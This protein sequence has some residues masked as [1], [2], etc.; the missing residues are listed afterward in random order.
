MVRFCLNALVALALFI[1]QNVTLF[2]RV[3]HSLDVV[4][5]GVTHE[6]PVVVRVV[7]GPDPRLVE[8]FGVGGDRGFEERLDGGSVARSERYVRLAK[9][10]ARGSRA[11]TTTNENLVELR[12]ESRQP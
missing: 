2:G 7:L 9:P 8:H 5:V 6:G 1:E 11:K 4:P 12:G 10:L 3:A